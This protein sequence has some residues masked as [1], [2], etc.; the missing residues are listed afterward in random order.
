MNYKS[1]MSQRNRLGN[2]YNVIRKSDK[3]EVLR[4]GSYNSTIS[5]IGEDKHLYEIYFY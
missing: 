5:L 3:K 2:L 4:G 1:F